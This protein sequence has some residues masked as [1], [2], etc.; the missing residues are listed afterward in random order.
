MKMREQ[1]DDKKKDKNEQREKFSRTYSYC[2]TYETL[3][4]MKKQHTDE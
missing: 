4:K 3:V 2:N 1:R